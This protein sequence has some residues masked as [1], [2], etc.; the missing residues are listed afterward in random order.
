MKLNELIVK[1]QELQ[2]EHGDSEVAI[3]EDDICQF[4]DINDVTYSAQKDEIIIN[5]L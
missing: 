3:W 5:N 4:R 1:L 2:K